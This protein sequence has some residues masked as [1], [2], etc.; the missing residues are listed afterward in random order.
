MA[1]SGDL[2]SMSLPDL[3]Q[4]AGQAG[5]TGT[6]EIA[7][8]KVA[9]RIHFRKGRLIGCSSD[10]PP[11]L[12]GQFLLSRGKIT[13]AQ[14]RDGLERQ[15]V[16]RDNLGKILV[17]MEA[18]SHDELV[19]QVTAKAEETIYGLFDWP[20][21]SFRFVEDAPP[22]P[23]GVDVDLRVED[24]LLHGLKR[25][26]EMNRLRE[27]FHHPGIVLR[28]SERTPPPE[29]ARN[30]TADAVYRSVDGRR[31][32][33]ELLLHGHA[34]EYYILKLLF[35]LLRGGLIEIAG[36]DESAA[37]VP[38]AAS[39]PGAAA[40]GAPH[41]GVAAR[42]GRVGS[43]IEMAVD[44]L[45]RNEP[46]AALAI[47]AAACRAHPG[48][49]AFREPTARA[50]A[51]C[52]E[53]AIR[54]LDPSSVPFLAKPAELLGAERLSATE[55]YLAGLLDGKSDIRTV[56]WLAPMREI[57][58]L[59]ALKSLLDRGLIALGGPSRAGSL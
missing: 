10:D 31:T 29:V 48:D 54:V 8:D 42:D 4:W 51:A 28:R 53:H 45:A 46:E 27:V 25:F 9:T 36:I 58:V 56:L 52:R 38:I 26:D 44:L 55:S 32:L 59:L 18:L 22:D 20:D 17:A 23:R 34:S 35:E 19:R 3:L 11:S 47:L 6:L 43:E 1:L 13:E 39:R 57:D 49:P 7:R 12:L 41:A 15:Q 21:A 30:K 37:T 16:T 33:A 24:V 50:E 40:S 5:K 2:S 14:L